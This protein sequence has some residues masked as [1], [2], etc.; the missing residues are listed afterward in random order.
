[1]LVQAENFYNA[2]ENF[3]KGMKGSMMDY[4]IASI[5]ETKIMDVIRYAARSKSEGEEAAKPEYE[6]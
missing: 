1:M 6:Q 5:Q 2:V 3:D 4:R